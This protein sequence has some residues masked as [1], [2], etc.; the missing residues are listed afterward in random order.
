MSLLSD[1]IA[2]KEFFSGPDGYDK[3]EVRAFLDVVARHQEALRE[4]IERLTSG[5][6]DVATVGAEVTT[7]LRT[8]GELADQLTSAAEAKAR[9]IRVR[10]EREAQELREAAVEATNRLK[11]EAEQY[12]FEARTTAE[13]VAREQQVLTADRIGRLLTGESHVRERLYS[14]EV[15]LQKMRGELL[16]AA[17]SV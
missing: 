3:E 9:E 11:E 10:A 1:E 4:E 16:D 12:A 14:L 2:R 15:T 6:P 17:E 13:R 8:A 7:V 5:E